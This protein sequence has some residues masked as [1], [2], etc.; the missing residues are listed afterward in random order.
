MVTRAGAVH[1]ASGSLRCPLCHGSP[2]QPLGDTGAH[3]CPSLLRGE[4]RWRSA[5]RE[6]PRVQRELGGGEQRAGG[7]QR[8][9]GQEELREPLAPLQAH[10]LHSLGQAAR[11]GG[12]AAL[13]ACSTV[14][15]PGE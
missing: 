10:V 4:P 9:H 14:C 3:W 11:K 6:V 1:D 8:Q 2:E 13:T 5:A 7:D 15:S 12:S